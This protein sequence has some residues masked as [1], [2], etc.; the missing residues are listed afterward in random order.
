MNL[1]AL[2]GSLAALALH[3]GVAGAQTPD[4]DVILRGGTVIDGTG[5][6]GRVADIALRRDRIAAI[7]SISE[8]ASLT[9]DAT[10]LIVAPG[11]IDMH[12]HSDRTRLL[13]PRGPSHSLQGVTTE[14]W[15]EDSSMGPLGGQQQ[16]NDEWQSGPTPSWKTL[17]LS[18][19]FGCVVVGLDVSADHRAGTQAR[20]ARDRRCL[21]V[22]VGYHGARGLPALVGARRRDGRNARPV[23]RSDGA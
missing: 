7:G 23:T 9:I 1:R 4:Y 17:G 15:G 22:H 8:Q 14:V 3:Y 6:P 11:F 12:S 20:T 16:P 2:L 13:D 5:K 19:E 10:G 18:S 21:S